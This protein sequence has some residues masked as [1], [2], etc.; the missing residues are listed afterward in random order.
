MTKDADTKDVDTEACA[1]PQPETLLSNIETLSLN[2]EGSLLKLLKRLSSKFI[3]PEFKEKDLLDS[4][5]PTLE[6]IAYYL[7]TSWE[8]VPDLYFKKPEKSPLACV[9]KPTFIEGGAVRDFVFKS[10]FVSVCPEYE[11][12]RKEMPENDSVRIRHWKHD[13]GVGKGTIIA[14]HGWMLGDDKAKALTMV[15][16]Y[17]YSL[18]FDVLVYEL[19]FHGGRA[20]KDIHP[21]KIFPSIDP[22]I[23]NESFAQAIFELRALKNWL[24]EDKVKP[25]IAMGLSLGAQTV[26]LWASLDKLDGIICVAP[27][28]SIAKRIWYYVKNSPLADTLTKVGLTEDLFDRAFS[29]STPLSYFLNV[30][31]D[32][33]LVIASKEDHIVPFEEVEMLVRHWDIPNTHFVPKGHVEQLVNEE[34]LVAVKKFLEEVVV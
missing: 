34:T 22:V 18:G 6:G 15:P 27:V 17:F 12:R 33:V 24:D 8:K 5:Q 10:K 20:P 2:P 4:V 29:P 11:K 31:K 25:V 3:V 1:Y 19:P 16:G 32:N 30:E 21:L 26:S 28:V 23:T 14:V 9:A 7:S 13:K